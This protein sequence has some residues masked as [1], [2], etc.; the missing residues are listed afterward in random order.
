MKALLKSIGIFIIVWLL[1]ILIFGEIISGPYYIRTPKVSMYSFWT[2]YICA[3]ISFFFIRKKEKEKQ[4][5]EEIADS[6]N[7]DITEDDEKA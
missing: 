4:T 6:R 3:M 2:A 1:S 5:R 7:L